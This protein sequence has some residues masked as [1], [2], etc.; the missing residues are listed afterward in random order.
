[1]L[2]ATVLRDEPEDGG[3][4]R[5]SS[6]RGPG[7]RHGRLD[8][9]VQVAGANPDRAAMF[10]RGEA[11]TVD[12]LPHVAHAHREVCGGLFHGQ[13]SVR[14]GLVHAARLEKLEQLPTPS[15]ITTTHTEQRIEQCVLVH[16]D[17]EPPPAN[18]RLR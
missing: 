17:H 8:V 7:A 5:S 14:A 12:R 6:C 16:G 11:P 15:R 18:A 4:P 10:L 3:Y 13:Q 2:A 9:R 1:M